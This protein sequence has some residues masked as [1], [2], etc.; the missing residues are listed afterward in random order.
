ML[1]FKILGMKCIS[2]ITFFVCIISCDRSKFCD[3]ITFFS[4]FPQNMRSSPRMQ[5]YK[6]LFGGPKIKKEDTTLVVSSFL[7]CVYEKD[8]D[9][10]PCAATVFWICSDVKGEC[11]TA[12]YVPIIL[13]IHIY[14]SSLLSKWKKFS[15]T[16]LSRQ[17]P[18]RLMLCRISFSRSIL[19]YRLSR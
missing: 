18:L 13:S 9:A 11:Y 12:S 17:L 7:P 4:L 8:A 10:N 2:L 16:V 19:R 5:K 14:L 6:F 1:F 3:F 15:I